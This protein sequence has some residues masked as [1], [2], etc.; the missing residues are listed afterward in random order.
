MFPEPP[1]VGVLDR[2][3]LPADGKIKNVIIH[4]EKAAGK[5]A[6][7]QI[8]VQG[9]PEARIYAVKV[10]SQEQLPYTMEL[11]VGS[12]VVFK[13]LDIAALKPENIWL[14]YIYEQ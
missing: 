3:M 14:S 1:P 5:Q 6:Q 13:L 10:G 11:A 12:Q 2:F 7:L 8:G 9:N 4:I